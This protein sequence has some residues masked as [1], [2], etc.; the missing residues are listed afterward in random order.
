MSAKHQFIFWVSV[1]VALIAVFTPQFSNF[2]EAF[3]FISMLFPVVIGTSYFFTLYLVPQYLLKQK[4]VRFSL[5]TIYMLVISIYLEMIVVII[6]LIIFA[7]YRADAMSPI[8]SDVFVLSIVLYLVVFIYSFYQLVLQYTHQAKE[9]VKLE[10]V[11][12]AE[13]VDF[14]RVRSNRQWIQCNFSEILYIESKADYVHV[15]LKNQKEPIVSKMR[16]SELVTQLPEPFLR[17]HRSFCVNFR[18]VHVFVNDTL[19][20]GPEKVPIP[21]SRT[22]KK[23]VREKLALD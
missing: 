20:L 16:I 14:L 22:Y 2:I 15:F 5:Y 11:Q 23:G 9:L 8:S 7:N 19:S 4:V 21:V 18:Y 13:K 17:V 12:S 3:F 6:S 1:F 10:E